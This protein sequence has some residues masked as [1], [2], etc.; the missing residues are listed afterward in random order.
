MK[1]SLV[2]NKSG[3]LSAHLDEHP[4][5]CISVC[6]EYVLF[7]SLAM[8]E[9]GPLEA[10]LLTAHPE[11]RGDSYDQHHQVLDQEQGQVRTTGALHLQT[12]THR[13]CLFCSDAH[14]LSRNIQKHACVCVYTLYCF[15]LQ[16][17]SKARKTW[18]KDAKH[19]TADTVDAVVSD[20]QVGAI[21]VGLF[22]HPGV[23]HLDAE[24]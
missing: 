23:I 15:I 9:A 7:A 22:E 6:V 21:T 4:E 11:H 19:D 12:H 14:F 2:L 18:P 16:R 8:E 20:W 1:N 3:R 17:T 13:M 24:V 10:G 5:V